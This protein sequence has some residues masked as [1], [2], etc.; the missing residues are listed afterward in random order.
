MRAPSLG[1]LAGGA[2]GGAMLLLVA[3]GAPPSRETA[4][5]PPPPP[6]A[7]ARGDVTLISAAISLPEEREALPAGQHADLVEARCTAC[8]SAGM[9]LTQ[10]P[11]SAQQWQAT[12]TKMRDVY[13]ADVPEQD[14]P[15][16]VAYLTGL[17]TAKPAS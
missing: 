9:M 6:A 4:Q 17:S 11:L 10:P 14:V 12:V 8:H 1:V 5:P 13:K 7:V 2:I 16:I 3:I 15:A